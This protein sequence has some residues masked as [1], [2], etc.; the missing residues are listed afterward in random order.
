[1]IEIEQ[2]IKNKIEKVKRLYRLYNLDPQFLCTYIILYKTLGMNKDLAMDA[3]EVLYYRVNILKENFDYD[4]FIRDKIKTIP[5]VQDLSSTSKSSAN[6]LK[7][8]TSFSG[9]TIK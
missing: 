3:M 1:M 8:I 9:V 4:S 2:D 6:L 7:D 5:V